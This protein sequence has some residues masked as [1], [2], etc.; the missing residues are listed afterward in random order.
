MASGNE[1]SV[2]KHANPTRLAGEG[3]HKN[4][5]FTLLIVTVTDNKVLLFEDEE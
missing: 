1:A 3:R 2:R 5:D 4:R